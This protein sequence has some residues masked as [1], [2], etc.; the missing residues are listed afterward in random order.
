MTEVSGFATKYKGERNPSLQILEC[1]YH[2]VEVKSTYLGTTTTDCGLSDPAIGII[3]H[4]QRGNLDIYSG[5][6]YLQF[7]Y[8][9]IAYFLQHI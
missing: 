7:I 9:L 2:F 8:T 1:C 6:T 4:E 5:L 3:H